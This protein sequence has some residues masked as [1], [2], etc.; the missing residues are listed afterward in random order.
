M[1]KILCLVIGLILV[2]S[3]AAC[4]SAENTD[5]EAAK[6]AQAGVM[7]HKEYLAAELDSTVTVETYIQAKQTWYDGKATFY[8]EAEDGAYF[9]YDMPCTK[10]EYDLLFPGTKIRVTG[11]K[12]EWSGEIE[13]TDAKFEMLESKYIAVAKDLTSLI[14][15]DE[16]AEH[17]N[18][19][20]TFKNLTIEPKTDKDGKE[21]AFLYNWDGSGKEGDDLY[22]SASIGSEPITFTVESNLYGPDTELYKAVKELK[23]GEAYDIT[24]FL[25][26]YE[27]ANPHVTAVS[28]AQQEN[29]LD[30]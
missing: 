8:T 26:W 7:T 12:A 10:E 19:Y 3:L 29:A 16:L 17:Q 14:G 9:I 28:P 11:K 6:K 1:K 15:S 22:F 25:Y 30:Y 13:I 4:G 20:V 27:G 24:G 23:I 18:E 2:F 5:S 21:T